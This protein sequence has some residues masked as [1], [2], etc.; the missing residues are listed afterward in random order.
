MSNMH[1]ILAVAIVFGIVLTLIGLL[2]RRHYEKEISKI[3]AA[4]IESRS[5]TFKKA[6]EQGFKEGRKSRVTKVIKFISKE[7]LSQESHAS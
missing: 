2:I 3:L 4:G 6:Y 5:N 7:V 1:N